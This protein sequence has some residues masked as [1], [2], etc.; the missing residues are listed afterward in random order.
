MHVSLSHVNSPGRVGTS[1][2]RAPGWCHPKCADS[3][4][5]LRGWL[6]LFCMVGE[7]SSVPCLCCGLLEGIRGT[8]RTSNFIIFFKDVKWNLHT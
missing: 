7:S 8:W 6:P 1:L 4:N 2:S 3:F 5:S